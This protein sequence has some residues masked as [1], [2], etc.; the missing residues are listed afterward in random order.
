MQ[1]SAPSLEQ[2]CAAAIALAQGGRMND[3]LAALRAII[4][5]APGDPRARRAIASLLLRAGRAAEALAE[6]DRTG[7]DAAPIL[8]SQ[9]LLALGRAD[10]AADAARMALASEP[11]NA[12][13]LFALGQAELSAQRVPDAERAFAAVLARHPEA[14]LARRGLVRCRLL[15]GRADLALADAAHAGVLDDATELGAML[16]E[17]A[18]AGALSERA[19]LLALRTERHPAD[20]ESALA[21]AASLHQLGDLGGALAHADRAHAL[22]SLESRP[23]EIRATAL[24]DRGDVETG[25]VQY[26]ELLAR[27]ADRETA[28]R[29]LV[30]MHYDPAQTNATLFASLRDFA[31]RHMPK[32]GPPFAAPRRSDS[33]RVRRIGWISPRFNEGP[34]ASFLTGLLAAFDRDAHRH[35]FIA[36][37]PGEDGA[38][39]RLRGLADEW[40]DLSGHDDVSLLQRLRALELD[41]AIDLAGH[42]T[43]NRLA[44]LAQR[45]APM[46]VSWL[47]WFDTTAVAAI[48]AWLSDGWLTPDDSTQRYT[49][50]LVRLDAGRFCYSPPDDAPSATYDGDGA[51]VFASFNRLAKLNA[52]VLETWSEILR[53]VPEARLELGTGLLADSATLA[54]TRDRFAALGVDTDRLRLHGRR[55][56]RELLAAYRRVDVALDPFPFSGCTTTCDALYMGAAVVTLPGETFV[57]RQSASLL[58]RLGRDAWIARDRDDYV[59][60]AV[61]LAADV[62]TS[63]RGRE[64]LR[65]DVTA[66]LC[67]ASAQAR[68]FAALLDRLCAR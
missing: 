64:L 2:R 27:A 11:D 56:Y 29:H 31:E 40:F 58:Q 50:R 43:A 63:R 38:T 6:L 30:L 28:A 24:I 16:A 15:N 44:V 49:E 18:A 22:R 12:A 7:A 14:P 47:D 13:A 8:R 33:Q 66:R 23:L 25:L 37:Q 32:L 10:A 26:R 42:S 4:D 36:L 67:D 34:V 1:H 55:P 60:R 59:E 68:D 19:R 35:L 45:V 62:A 53:R 3:A 46:Q 61:A 65:G 54:H 51:I 9:T 20:Y 57:S 52:N 39:R 5:E 21:L 17:F 48:D 41:V